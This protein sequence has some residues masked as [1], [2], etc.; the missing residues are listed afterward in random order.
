[1]R[2]SASLIHVE[3]END[4]CSSRRADILARGSLR[5]YQISG[6]G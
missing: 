3:V 5:W 1:V 4:D 6:S 2:D